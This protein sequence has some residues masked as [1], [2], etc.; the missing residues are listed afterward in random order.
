M[1][2][3]WLTVPR[4]L[5]AL[6]LLAVGLLLAFGLLFGAG[7]ARY[8]QSIVYPRALDVSENTL[9]VWWPNP[10]VRRTLLLRTDDGFGKVFGWYSRTFEL[11]PEQ[12]AIGQ[13]S[14]MAR[15]RDVLW[16]LE[17]DMSVQVCN[18]PNGRMVFVMRSL[19]FKWR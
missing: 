12:H 7:V 10:T 3:R 8:F 1:L 9:Y 11:G 4:M 15:S 19:T 2:E 14:L 16:L 13:C 5:L 17:G 6:S 18:T